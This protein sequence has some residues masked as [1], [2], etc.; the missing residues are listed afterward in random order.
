LTWLC[1]LCGYHRGLFLFLS[2]CFR[3]VICHPT[4]CVMFNVFHVLFYVFAG[5]ACLIFYGTNNAL[6]ASTSVIPSSHK[7][8][9]SLCY[10]NVD[11]FIFVVT[12][13]RYDYKPVLNILVKKLSVVGK[14]K[15]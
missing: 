2:A 15:P 5:T 10:C 6:L 1:H 7:I 9:T 13:M 8:V 12:I 4:I 3:I 14:C 11:H